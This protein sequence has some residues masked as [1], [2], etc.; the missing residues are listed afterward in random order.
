MLAA[1]AVQS[2]DAQTA[3]VAQFDEA[4]MDSVAREQYLRD[5]AL[6]NA[7]GDERPPI[8][9]VSGTSPFGVLLRMPKSGRVSA[10]TVS[11][12]RPGKILTNAHCVWGYRTLS[13]G[14]FFLVFYDKAGRKV[15]LPVE[16]FEYVGKPRADDI[17][18]L[19]ISADAAAKWDTVKGV[20]ANRKEAHYATVWA[21]DPIDPDSS[22][23]Q[24][25][26]RGMIFSPRQCLASRRLPK[27]EGIKENGE[28]VN[29][30]ADTDAR[31]SL[32]VFIDGCTKELGNG[33]SGALITGAYGISELAGVYHWGIKPTDGSIA[34]YPQLEYTGNGGE[35]RILSSNVVSEI[36]GVGFSL[37]T[38]P[39]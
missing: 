9:P 19:R 27:L 26:A 15:H 13:A 36:F 11:H 7:A 28:R 35:P 37:S 1:C 25:Y 30:L 2:Q 24:K 3:D 17:A 22:P 10:C 18:V 16:G 5:F 39:L 32:H 6:L 33:N 4:P 23:G 12:V 29:I 14:G 38:F 21:F 34:R 31:E 20:P 8:D